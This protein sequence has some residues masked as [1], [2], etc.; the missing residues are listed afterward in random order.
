MGKVLLS[1]LCRELGISRRVIQG[2][3]SAGLVKATS[4]NKYGYL[5][6]DDQAQER[7]KLVRD[8]QRIGFKISEI[9]GIIDADNE[10]LKGRLTE[11]I[12]VLEDQRVQIEAAIGL[13]NEKLSNL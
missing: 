10:V 13:A 2:M 12:K 3:E 7:I 11:Q 5:E 9:A 8:Y 4:K 6:Y 1:E